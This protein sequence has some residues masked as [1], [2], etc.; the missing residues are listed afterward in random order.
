ML[1]AFTIPLIATFALS[2][3][4]HWARLNLH[5]VLALWMLAVY[6]VGAKKSRLWAEGVSGALILGGLLTI[7]WAEPA[8]DVDRERLGRLR[9]MS[10]LERATSRDG[11]FT[12]L[13]NETA[14]ARERELGDGDLVVFS[15]VP[16]AGL[17]WNERFS[18][19]LEWIDPHE[20]RGEAWL[21]EASRR[22][23]SW[24]VV[25][26]RSSLLRL[27]RASPSWEEVGPADGSNEPA[28]AF[29]ARASSSSSD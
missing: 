12:L 28:F 20:H 19:R 25:E 13:P 11:I 29:R 17:L 2:P 5:V 15:S 8:W 9:G 1:L 24:A 26:H 14:L 18:N 16:F 22:G 7:W 27:L 23:A 4:R 6:V 10:A 3:A 21:A